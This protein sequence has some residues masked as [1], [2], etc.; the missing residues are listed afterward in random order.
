VRGDQVIVITGKYRG[1]QGKVLKVNRK[2]NSVLVQGINLKLKRFKT[3]LDNDKK[4][5]IRPIH[6]PVHVS[7]VSLIDP[8]TGKPTRVKFGYL[9][10][11]T[12]IRISKKSGNIIAKPVYDKTKKLEKI[13]KTVDGTMDTPPSL[14]IK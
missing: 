2:L 10:D 4:G 7:N 5:G 8:E 14:V 13:Q 3:D 9:E 11:G 1:K 12:E 6:H